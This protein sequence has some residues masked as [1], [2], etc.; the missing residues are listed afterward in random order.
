MYKDLFISHFLLSVSIK[1]ISCYII[2]WKFKPFWLNLFGNPPL[3]CLQYSYSR[4]TWQ[5][6]LTLNRTAQV[7]IGQSFLTSNIEK[8]SDWPGLKPSSTRRWEVERNHNFNLWT[9]IMLSG[10]ADSA[11]NVQWELL[12]NIALYRLGHHWCG[13]SCYDCR[14]VLLWKSC[15]HSM[16]TV[17]EA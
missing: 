2:I 12:P 15:F 8:P 17:Y 10:W 16:F 9:E 3:Q 14:S 11:Q 4:K 6:N 5:L 13:N 1:N 7:L